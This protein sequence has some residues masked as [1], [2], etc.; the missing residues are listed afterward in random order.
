[1][2]SQN[3]NFNCSFLDGDNQIKSCKTFI[4]DGCY[5]CCFYGKCFDCKNLDTDKCINCRHD[6]IGRLGF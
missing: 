1:M 5:S 4:S 6:S 2:R 3:D